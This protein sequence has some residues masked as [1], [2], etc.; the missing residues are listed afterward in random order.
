[1]SSQHSE[2]GRHV[3]VLLCELE[4]A[5]VTI[6]DDCDIGMGAIILPGR[7]I[8]RGSIVGA[9]AVVTH[10]VEPYTVVAGVPA[11]SIGERPERNPA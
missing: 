2:E 10:D 11:R 1:M 7:R 6:E 5:K 3:P 8:G 9:G 4:F